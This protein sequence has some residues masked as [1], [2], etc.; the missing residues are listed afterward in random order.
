M[1][2]FW[3]GLF[4]MLL[5]QTSTKKKIA[6]QTRLVSRI[7]RPSEGC[8]E[9]KINNATSKIVIAARAIRYQNILCFEYKNLAEG[10]QNFLKSI[11]LNDIPRV[12]NIQF[13]G[14]ECSLNIKSYSTEE[15]EK[16]K[17]YIHGIVY[18]FFEEYVLLA[19]IREE[20]LRLLKEL[21]F[22]NQEALTRDFVTRNYKR[23]S[24]RK[25]E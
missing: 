24:R 12:E 16:C 11:T 15:L 9:G 8:P 6:T 20:K 10:T 2:E 18:M 25:F 23:C 19:A 17:D 13:K 5:L 14:L 3:E 22:K 7:Q 4:F 1:T 21:E